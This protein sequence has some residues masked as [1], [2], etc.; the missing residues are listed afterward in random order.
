MNDLTDSG[1]NYRRKRWLDKIDNDQEVFNRRL[2]ESISEDEA[3]ALRTYLSSLDKVKE[4]IELGIIPDKTPLYTYKFKDGKIFTLNDKEEW[5]E[6]IFQETKD[7]SEKKTDISNIENDPETRRTLH[8][9]QEERGAEKS[10]ILNLLFVFVL[11]LLGGIGIKS[12]MAENSEH[13]VRDI[14]ARHLTKEIT[15]KQALKK[16]K[17]SIPRRKSDQYYKVPKNKVNAYCLFYLNGLDL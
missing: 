7:K 3:D 9:V 10:K 12:F 2:S 4:D 15:Y 5:I 14:C 11:G 17:L 1:K 8:K 16:L 6:F 13:E